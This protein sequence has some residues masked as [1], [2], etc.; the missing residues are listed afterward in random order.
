[1]GWRSAAGRQEILEGVDHLS[2]PGLDRGLEIDVAVDARQDALGSQLLQA[3][4]EIGPGL[5]E[6]RVAVVAKSE[7]GEVQPLQARRAL[8]EQEAVEFDRRVRRVAFPLGT[9]HQNQMAFAAKVRGFVVRCAYCY[10]TDACGKSRPR[11]EVRHLRRIAGLRSEENGQLSIRTTLDVCRRGPVIA[12]LK[13]VGCGQIPEQP[14]GLVRRKTG[15]KGVEL[16]CLRTGKRGVLRVE[17]RNMHRSSGLCLTQPPDASGRR[18][19]RS[20]WAVVQAAA[21]LNASRLRRK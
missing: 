15:G 18:P 6:I 13:A 11:E 2:L 17:W 7:H 9:R 5:A 10:R 21:S 16:G 19:N 1:M 4:V 14:G 12:A 3:T 8:A 20:L